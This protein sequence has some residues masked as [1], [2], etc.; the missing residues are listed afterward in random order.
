MKTKLLFLSL[1]VLCLSA[2]PAIA[3]LQ[4]RMDSLEAYMS[5]TTGDAF[6]AT[7]TITLGTGGILNVDLETDAGGSW[8][9]LDN[10]QMLKSVSD[11]D[12]LL[13]NLTFTK[14]AV[15]NW[16]ATGN[17]TI[18]DTVGTRV[19]ADF[20]SNYVAINAA[21]SDPGD[22][23]WF[24]TMA[25]DLDPQS[26]TSIL[27]NGTSGGS[28]TFLGEFTKPGAPNADGTL[29]QV[30]VNGWELWSEGTLLELHLQVGTGS[31]DTFFTTNGTYQDGQLNVTITPIPGAVLLGVLGLGVVGWK[32]RKYA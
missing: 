20:T 14:V 2:A 17:L 1:A 12:F 4:L 16:T 11:P 32:L 29:N 3:G 19:L 28:W 23:E 21:S 25:G 9:D 8:A 15:D 13:S 24:F 31:L 26:P 18:S 5:V 6:N 30:T 22:P 10:A 27:V 7:G